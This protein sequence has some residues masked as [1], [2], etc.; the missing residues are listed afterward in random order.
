MES[1]NLSY[2]DDISG[3]NFHWTKI[4]LNLSTYSGLNNPYKD[5]A[6]QYSVKMEIIVSLMSTLKNS[7]FVHPRLVNFQN[8]NP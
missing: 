3:L 5:K 1:C 7:I 2:Y 8:M 6:I 4:N